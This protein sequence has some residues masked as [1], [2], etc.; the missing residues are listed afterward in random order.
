[1]KGY[2]SGLPFPTP[3]TTE[4]YLAL[5]KKEIRTQATTGTNPKDIML[6][7][8]INQAEKDM[9]FKTEK[10]DFT[11]TRCLERVKLRETESRLVVARHWGK[12]QGADSPCSVG[13]ESLF[14]K[15]QVFWSWTVVTA[16]HDVNRLSATELCA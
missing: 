15:L 14:R 2:R 8:E 3:H 13:R 4:Y 6:S 11:Y 1:M 7:E 10:Y 16:A 12:R 9:K 5:K